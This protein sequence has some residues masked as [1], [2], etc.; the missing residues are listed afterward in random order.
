MLNLPEDFGCMSFNEATM[1]ERLPKDAYI[2]LKRTREKGV[3]LDL[4]VANVVANCMKDWAIEK[5]ATHFTHWFQPLNGIT[6]EKH[7]GFIALARATA[8]LLWSSQA[9]S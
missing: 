6:A 1:R 9:R 7:E 3:P 8:A 4:N 2:A 5:G